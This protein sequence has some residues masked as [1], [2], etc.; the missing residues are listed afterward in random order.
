GFVTAG[1]EYNHDLLACETGLHGG[2]LPAS[3]SLG[4]VST[5]GRPR[6]AAL[7]SALKPRGNPL[8]SG[9]PGRPRREAGV[10]IPLRAAARPPGAPA[11]ARGRLLQGI[12]AARVPD[13]TE[14]GDGPAAGL[15][16]GRA[17]VAAPPAGLVTVAATT[18]EAPAQQPLPVISREVA[19]QT[20]TNQAS[21]G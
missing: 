9:Q 4:E 20:G 7:L 19:R 8:A 10:T 3:A 14:E 16:D 11:P 6:P 2:P 17:L 21:A 13:L 15:A 1:Q 5:P 12:T 18:P